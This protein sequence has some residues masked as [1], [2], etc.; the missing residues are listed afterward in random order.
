MAYIWR[1]SAKFRPRKYDWTDDCDDVQ[2][3]CEEADDHLGGDGDGHIPAGVGDLFGEM[4]GQSVFELWIG[5]LTY[6][7]ASGVPTE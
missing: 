7:V 1:S 5:V 3:S 2:E 6:V 4:T